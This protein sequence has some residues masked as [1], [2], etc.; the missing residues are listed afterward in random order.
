MVGP[1]KKTYL[2]AC[3][4]FTRSSLLEAKR[5]GYMVANIFLSLGELSLNL[6]QYLFANWLI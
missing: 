5:S 4:P 3:V 1:L 2:K 6:G